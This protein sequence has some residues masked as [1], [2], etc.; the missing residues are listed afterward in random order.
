M[1]TQQIQQS[2]A[3]H[4]WKQELNNLFVKEEETKSE[5]KQFDWNELMSDLDELNDL[6]AFIDHN[7]FDI[8]FA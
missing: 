2:N 5:N 4:N 8:V 6:D 7:E 1:N 3:L